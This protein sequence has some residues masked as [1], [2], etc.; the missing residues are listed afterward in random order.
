[1]LNLLLIQMK[2]AKLAD[3]W[4][5]DTSPESAYILLD[6]LK[7]L[8][9]SENPIDTTFL[10]Y[11]RMPWIDALEKTGRLN[12][13]KHVDWNFSGEDL[14]DRERIDAVILQ[15]HISNHDDKSFEIVDILRNVESFAHS[16]E[17][18]IHILYARYQCARDSKEYSLALS[19]VDSMLYYQNAVADEIIKESVKGAQRDFYSE[20][21]ILHEHRSKLFKWLLFGSCLVS[22][23]LI[24]AG[25]IFYIFKNKA[26]KAKFQANLEALISIKAQSD[27]ILRERNNLQQLVNEVGHKNDSMVSQI[28]A[29]K[30]SKK[31]LQITHSVI[32]EKLFKEKWTTLDA[33]CDQ[34]YG[35]NNS[36]LTAHALVCNMQK[37]VNKIVSRKGLVEIVEAVDTYMNGIVSNLRTQCKFLK[38]GDINF[39]ALLF[40][41]FSVRAVCMFTSIKYDYFY[42]KKSRLIKRIEAADAPDKILFL[43]KLQ[44]SY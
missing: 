7:N 5:N 19:L 40:A 10:E 41:G 13:L 16:D 24:S 36:E 21:S 31:Q 1:M 42:V 8:S 35:L 4:L 44:S 28:D 39:L 43:Q 32:V 12:N 3:I 27:Y 34:Y 38:E 26:Q 29:L 23:L 37:E 18:R 17:D 2:L 6:S 14:S 11:I 33:L 9:L 22:I 30:N 20:Q 15:S 25:V